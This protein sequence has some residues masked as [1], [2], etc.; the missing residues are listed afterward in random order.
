MAVERT[1]GR[2]LVLTVLQRPLVYEIA[3]DGSTCRA[4]VTPE[5]FDPNAKLEAVI[6]TDVYTETGRFRL[7][8]TP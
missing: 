3:A 7:V 8:P 4:Y 6:G 5:W 1:S 2:A